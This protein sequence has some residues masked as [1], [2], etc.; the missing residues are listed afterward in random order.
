MDDQLKVVVEVAID[1][2]KSEQQINA[3]LREVKP[4]TLKIA[5]EFDNKNMSN[6]KKQL[7]DIAKEQEKLQGFSNSKVSIKTTNTGEIDTASIKYYNELT[8]ETVTQLYIIDK[9][10]GKLALSTKNLTTDYQA[11]AKAEQSTNKQ[12]LDFISN[13]VV[14]LDKLK[15]S[16]A[17][18]NAL[19][20]LI[21][22]NSTQLNSEYDKIIAKT[23][24]LKNADKI[25]SEEIQREIKSEISSY[26]LLI[27]SKQNS[28]Y[29]ATSLRTKDTTTINTSEVNNL[30]KFEAQ[31]KNSSVSTNAM[32][33]DLKDLHTT[34]STAFDA[35]SL[36]SYL[37]KLDVAKSKFGALKEESKVKI[38][39]TDTTELQNQTKYYDKIQ[40]ELIT[41]QKL[42]KQLVN[43]GAEETTE[44]NR[45]IS[46]AQKR[47]TYDE[48][49][50]QKKQLY[51]Q[52]LA[53]E[54]NQIKFVQDAE[55]KIISAKQIDKTNN[56][57]IQKQMQEQQKLQS[58][59]DQ[60]NAQNLN[61]IDLE[62]Q[63][64]EQASKTF[65]NQLKSQMQ[66]NVD[67]TSQANLMEKLSTQ[68]QIGKNRLI[69]F[70]KELKGA[71]RQEYATTINS[72][73]NSFDNVSKSAN[74]EKS[75]KQA[76]LSLQEFQSNMK[77]TGQ[78]G[79]TF[80]TKLGKNLYNFFGF[81]GSATIAMSAINGVRSMIDNVKTLDDSLTNLRMV[82][83]DSAENTAKLLQSYND[84]GKQLGATTVE[85]ADSGNEWLR[86]G[87]SIADTNTLIKDSM[88]LSKVANISSADSTMYLTSA[89]K[90][91]GVATKD[92]LGIVDKLNAVDLVSATS[93]AGLAEA[94]SKTANMANL[95]G[96]SMDKLLGY[97][98]TVSEVTQKESSA[99]GESFQSIFSRLG[100]VKAGKFIDDETGEALDIW[101]IVA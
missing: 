100:N 29:V 41:I 36:T 52:E 40:Q 57:S 33:T 44:L 98:A 77:A 24:E 17:D 19:K 69:A 32:E 34:L 26:E 9:E 58:Q 21:G 25:R 89:M 48:Q 35:D 67:Y 2:S 65:S 80:L 91:Y 86:Q 10:T 76:N 94:M 39:G 95:S 82:T 45:Q 99:V 97:I 1:K 66:G 42:K 5:V 37:N 7:A 87:K 68:A 92:T 30:R 50:I 81:L 71:A 93:A 61:A 78:V 75:L 72:I 83:G 53:K 12:R 62:I 73:A 85:V 47:V 79:D 90:G 4:E 14:S 38:T 64:Q 11:Q 88:I 27:K 6:L 18:S 46:N 56:N 28:Q 31:I 74:P 20:P 43:A 60:F 96:I 22:D 84:L 54:V 13:Q 55:N 16:Y 70:A 101:G 8:K 49:Q 23:E 15:A 59:K 63:K 3:R 51:N